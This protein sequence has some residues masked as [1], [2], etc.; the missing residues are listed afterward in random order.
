MTMSHYTHNDDEARNDAERSLSDVIAE[1]R[2]K[3]EDIEAG[4]DITRVEAAPP[5]VEQGF[6][7]APSMFAY[8]LRMELIERENALLDKNRK[9]GNSALEPMRVF[10]RSGPVEQLDVRIDDKL[11]RIRSRQDDDDE[12][13][14]EDLLGYLLLKRVA[15]RMGIA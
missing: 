9:Y 5:P 1:L 8:H 6:P 13:A 12:D 4:R 15:K 7:P 2:R 3:R 10:S 11:S 14:E